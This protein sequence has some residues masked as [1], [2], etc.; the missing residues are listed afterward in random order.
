MRFRLPNVDRVGLVMDISRIL[1]ERHI[2][3]LSMEVDLRV[4]FLEVQPLSHHAAREL[5]EC[6]LTVPG[7]L[8]VEMIDLMPHQERSQQIQKKLTTVQD[9]ITA[10]DRYGCIAF[11]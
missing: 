9:G 3:I 8:D 5:A 10:V 4:I 7:I 2:N 1:A 6:L 11:C